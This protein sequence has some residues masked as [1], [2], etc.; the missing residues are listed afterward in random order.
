M[1]FLSRILLSAI[2]LSGCTSNKTYTVFPQYAPQVSASTLSAESV[3]FERLCE[4]TVYIEVDYGDYGYSGSG[5][6]VDA[7][8]GVILTAAHVV[9]EDKKEK[10]KIT[11]GANDGTVYKVE[12]WERFPKCDLAFLFIGKP[13]SA[14]GAVFAQVEPELGDEI[15]LTGTPYKKVLINSLSFGRIT[16]LDRKASLL[17]DILMYQTDAACVGGNSGG[18]WFDKQGNVVGI[19]SMTYGHSG[20][21]G[22]G[23]PLPEILKILDREAYNGG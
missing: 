23:V 14:R 6:V 3:F 12:H 1:K 11:V 8:N 18:P 17:P 2:L 5:V 21:L 7:E 13:I 20:N 4:S 16:G 19:S 9:P 15:V 22:L 10:F